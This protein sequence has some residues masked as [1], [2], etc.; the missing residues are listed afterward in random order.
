MLTITAASVQQ[1]LADLRQRYP[2]FRLVTK[3]T[4]S[5]RC[6]TWGTLIYVPETWDLLSPIT[7]W[8]RLKHESV[9]LEQFQR[10]GTIRF[11]WQYLWPST[12]YAIEQQAYR[13]EFVAICQ[14]LGAQALQQKRDYYVN[15]LSGSA[16]YY[17]ASRAKAQVWVDQT[18][19]T[20]IKDY[21]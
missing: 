6:T 5:D 10:Y 9:H 8:I 2:D 14:A 1:F 19:T 20:V 13:E 21:A 16:Y 12:R 17:C 11:L 3:S 4:S 15:L 7:Q 18:I